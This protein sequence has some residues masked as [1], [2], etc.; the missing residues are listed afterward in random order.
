MSDPKTTIPASPYKPFG[1]V[2][3]RSPQAS[4]DEWDDREKA[5]YIMSDIQHHGV[6]AIDS[7][8]WVADFLVKLL[9]AEINRSAESHG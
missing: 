3:Y 7:D 4:A 6:E 1:P 5:A 8:Q 9:W 2:Q